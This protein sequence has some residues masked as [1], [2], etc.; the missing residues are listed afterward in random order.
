MMS[1][2]GSVRPV[3]PPT[4]DRSPVVFQAAGG[5]GTTQAFICTILSASNTLLYRL[6]LKGGLIRRG[7]VGKKERNQSP[8]DEKMVKIWTGKDGKRFFFLYGV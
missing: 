7:R 1:C 3:C 6:F 2:W 8:Y 5:R 4:A